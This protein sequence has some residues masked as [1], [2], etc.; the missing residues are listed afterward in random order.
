[1][2]SYS[3]INRAKIQKHIIDHYEGRASDDGREALDLLREEFQAVSHNNRTR[4]EAARAL[5]EGGNFEVYDADAR[6]FV[7]SLNLDDTGR[8]YDDVDAWN[9]Y[10]DL[11][12]R[13]IRNLVEDK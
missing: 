9:K 13:E 12:A 8:E 1:M 2:K 7:D 10:C 11:L 5:V 6:A 3:K 4:Q